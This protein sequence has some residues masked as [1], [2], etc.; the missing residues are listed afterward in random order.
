MPPLKRIYIMPPLESCCP[1][2]LGVAIGRGQLQK[3]ADTN[4]YNLRSILGYGKHT[5]YK[6]LLS[7]AVG[8][9]NPRRK[10]KILFPSFGI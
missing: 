8:C 2:F 1:L 9:E 6:H 3:L 5:P 4:D 7:M 10:K